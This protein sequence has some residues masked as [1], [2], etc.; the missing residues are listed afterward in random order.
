[1]KKILLIL[2][3]FITLVASAQLTPSRGWLR[4]DSLYIERIGG[5]AEMI[6]K[7]ATRDTTGV[8]YNKGGGRTEF[9]RTL[10][11]KFTDPQPGDILVL[12]PTGD[13]IINQRPT[14]AQCSNASNIGLSHVDN[15]TYAYTSGFYNINCVQYLIETGGTFTLD[16][17]DGDPGQFR[18]DEA[19]LRAGIGIVILK[20]ENSDD[21]VGG[22][23]PLDP[24]TDILLSII[25]INSDN[26]VVN[27]GST[28]IYYDSPVWTWSTFGTITA[29]NNSA[30]QPLAPSA[31]SIRITVL[32]N[33]A[34]YRFTAPSTQ[35]S[36]GKRLTFFLRHDATVNNTRNWVIRKMNGAN[37][38]NGSSAVTL[39]TAKGFN[40]TAA[41]NNLWQLISIPLD[42]ATN[43]FGGQD[44]YTGFEFRNTG[45]GGTV[46]QYVDSIRV[47]S[48]VVTQGP[49]VTQPNSAKVYN[50]VTELRAANVTSEVQAITLGYYAINDGGGAQ[51]YWDATSTTAD[52]GFLVIKSQNGTGRW[53]LILTNYAN[54]RWAG[55]KGDGS[56]D[57][58]PAIIKVINAL[59]AP[60]SAMIVPDG[61]FYSSDSIYINKNISIV[62]TGTGVGRRITS[63]FKFPAGKKGFIVKF[64]TIAATSFTMNNIWVQGNGGTDTL[65]NGFWTNTKVYMDNVCFSDFSGNGMKFD[66]RTGGNSNL[67]ILKNVDCNQNKMNGL[68]IQGGDCNHMSFYNLSATTNARNNVWDNGFLGNH[69]YTVHTS[70]AGM[71]AGQ[72][73]WVSHGGHYFVYIAVDA[74]QNIEPEVTTGWQ[75]YWQQFEGVENGAIVSAWASGTTYFP[76]SAFAIVGES[77]RSTVTAL[78]TEESQGGVI[79]AGYGK[80]YG[81]DNGAGFVPWLSRRNFETA[82]GPGVTLFESD[83]KVKDANNGF[84]AVELNRTRG[85]SI[86]YLGQGEMSYHYD[87]TDSGYVI[88][89]NSS[90][91][92]KVQGW[93]WE[94]KTGT[95]FGRSGSFGFKPVPWYYKDGVWFYDETNLSA[96]NFRFVSSLPGS[97]TGYANGDLIFISDNSSDGFYKNVSG[98][99]T[100]IGSGGGGG[101]DSPDRIDGIATANVNAD[102]ATF[103]LVM[104]N[105]NANFHIYA[106]GSFSL[107]DPIMNI[108]IDAGEGSATFNDQRGT[109]VGWE[110]AADYSAGFTDLSIIN[111]AA[112][113]KYIRQPVIGT[114]A[115][116]STITPDADSH[117][118][119]TVTALATNPTFAAP[120]GT[121]ADGQILII[122]IKDNGTSRT[123]TWNSIYRAGTDITLP[124]STTI[125]KT[126]YL[127]FAYND[128]DSKWDFIGLTSGF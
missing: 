65:A 119:Y 97:T 19:I 92:Y 126:M 23:V 95:Q 108:N 99:W 55:A 111:K 127:Q 11:F 118:V 128:A 76:S 52:D 66:T 10:F 14:P 15:L 43:G 62:G 102:L 124:T 74:Q 117:N 36:T 75:S 112:A 79:L 37:Q 70:F 1:M 125:S 44:S 50:T 69:Y 30:V 17:F 113:L 20:G 8:L 49:P 38:V 68:E 77:N 80:I 114:T 64:E 2:S 21:Q 3:C 57:D 72:R 45:T 31:K 115:S 63:S 110:Y 16:D 84:F 105:T 48:G 107:S 56:T 13:T 22:T 87:A 34:G 7:N 88:R 104:S 123:I 40:K 5:N 41:Y 59:T 32:N 9:R 109:P 26:E 100:A 71:F 35:S 81:G 58:R 18:S 27:I 93:A 61:N 83:V 51:Y 28:T 96:R 46:L 120:S 121:P 47:E 12:D 6:L 42:D 73:S 82:E 103:G 90:P 85:L 60:Y 33:N 106:D 98:T 101:S 54:L 24:A 39:T 67:S 91:D 86:N 78:Y 122:R 94:N 53:K 25:T 4:Y 89:S 116:A 29:D